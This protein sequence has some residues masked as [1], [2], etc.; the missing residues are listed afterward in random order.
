MIAWLKRGRGAV[1]AIALAIMCFGFATPAM[2]EG[3]PTYGPNNAMLTAVIVGPADT[4]ASQDSYVF[5]FAGGGDVVGEKDENEYEHVYSGGIEQD[6]TTIKVGDTVPTIPDVKLNGVKLTGDNSLSNGTVYQAVVQKSIFGILSESGVVFPHAGIYTYV[7]TETSSSAQAKDCCINASSKAEY[8][9]RIRVKN[10]ASSSASNNYEALKAVGLE[11]DGITVQQTKDDY[12]STLDNAPK[13][14][15]TN[16]T[17]GAQST[18]NALAGDDRGFNVPGFTFANEYIKCAPFQVKK[19][20]DGNFSDKTKYSTVKL[21]IH[22]TEAVTAV[23]EGSALTYTIEGGGTDSTQNAKTSNGVNMVEFD[24][25]GWAYITAELKEGSSIRITGMLGPLSGDER[26]T[27]STVGLTSGLEYYVIE[28]NPGDYRPTGY[29]YEGTSTDVDPRKS[30]TGMSKTNNVG[31]SP[32][33]DFGSRYDGSISEL[34][35]FALFVEGNT[36]GSDT[37]VFVVNSLDENKVSPTGILIDNLPYILMIGIPVIVFI[38]L[39][40]LRRRR[41][42][43]E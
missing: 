41:N 2:A 36:T 35:A 15:P 7:V 21:T 33:Q 34:P 24:S 13:V 12:G 30:D 42:A 9:V 14:D 22:S 17:V 27:I 18:S 19:L 6:A 3:E 10:S 31:D 1:A 28:D 40:V 39:F 26:E 29:V 16:S 11:I 23:K 43:F 5:H 8:I 4:D 32:I 37:T 25:N 20:Y 38:A